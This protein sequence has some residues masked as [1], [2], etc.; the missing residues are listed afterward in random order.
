MQPEVQLDRIEGDRAHLRRP[1]V[2]ARLPPAPV[3]AK[4]VDLEHAL[5]RV[6]GG[7]ADEERCLGS[8]EGS[9]GCPSAV[10]RRCQPRLLRGRRGVD[11]R[12]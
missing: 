1:L 6:V 5:A 11:L 8:G 3:F 7:M 9:K 4:A 10:N 12:L 2:D